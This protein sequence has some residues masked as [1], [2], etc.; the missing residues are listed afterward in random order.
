MIV[1]F[2][3]AVWGETEPL[4]HKPP[5]LMDILDAL[6]LM[7]D[8]SRHDI[9]WNC[10]E[11]YWAIA[12]WPKASCSAQDIAE[13]IAMSK[14]TTQ[15]YLCMAEKAGYIQSQ[16]RPNKYSLVQDYSADFRKRIEKFSGFARFMRGYRD[17]EIAYLESLERQKIYAN[18]T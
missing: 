10:A 9:D 1:P 18:K 7:P 13:G 12:D 2:D 16:G 14:S 11:V 4:E 6:G 15:K 8:V 5:K 3:S 17:A